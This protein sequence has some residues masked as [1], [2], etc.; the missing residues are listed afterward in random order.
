V[1]SADNGGLYLGN[2]HG[3][4]GHK[5]DPFDGGT[6]GECHISFVTAVWFP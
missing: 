5:Y 3:L 1:F 6:R 4:R 2:N